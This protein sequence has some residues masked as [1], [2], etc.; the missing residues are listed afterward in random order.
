[1]SDINEPLLPVKKNR[2]SY[3][4]LYNLVSRDFKLKY[5]RSVLGVLWSV[6]NPLLSMVVMVLVFSNIFRFD[7][8]NFPVYLILGQVLMTLMT[9]STNNSM[10]SII[11][12]APLIQKIYVEK[13]IFP[14]EKC[15][16]AVVNFLLSL[17]A[18][19]GVMI[20]FHIAP[21]WPI[22]L[23]P[24]VILYVL[25]FSL[26][27]SYLLSAV[28]VFFRDVM[29][30]WGVL[31]TLWFYLTPIFWP[32]EA[33]ASNGISW[34]YQVILCNPMYHYVLYFRNIMMY[35][36]WPSL[37]ENLICIAFALGTLAIGLFTF[38]KLEKKFILY[39]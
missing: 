33:L 21:G 10:G 30:L 34:M 32:I 27:L 18:V 6:L 16:F 26:G 37:T 13:I 22:V 23:L 8:E 11:E 12:A 4:L 38:K 15:I 25:I 5:R 1:M 29:H 9:D 7:I 36:T 17:I 2:N 19:A 31:V 20:F 3:Y 28:S 24:V 14:T 39:I 35:N